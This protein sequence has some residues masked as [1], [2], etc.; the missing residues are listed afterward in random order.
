MTNIR[1]FTLLEYFCK[2]AIS[3]NR[4]YIYKSEESYLLHNYPKYTKD[5]IKLWVREYIKNHSNL[6]RNK[7]INYHGH[8]SINDNKDL[9][10]PYFIMDKSFLSITN[11]NNNKLSFSDFVICILNEMKKINKIDISEKSKI[12]LFEDFING[13]S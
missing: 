12:L 13:N 10:F 9:C 11:F 4:Y 1:F 3:S 5:F 6:Y 2:T 8:N 7:S